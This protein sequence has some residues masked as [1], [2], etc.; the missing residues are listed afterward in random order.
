MRDDISKLNLPT[1]AKR[2]ARRSGLAQMGPQGV[3]DYLAVNKQIVNPTN[4]GVMKSND[5]A[6]TTG[7]SPIRTVTKKILGH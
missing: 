6:Q 5:A 2:Y 7:G 4:N 3:K 1:A